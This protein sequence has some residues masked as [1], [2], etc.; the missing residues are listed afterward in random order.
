MA[1]SSSPP[2]VSACQD[3]EI[4]TTSPSALTPARE[5]WLRIETLHAVTYFDPSVTAAS[6][7]LGLRG[8]WRGYF[9][10]RAAPLGPVAGGVV[11]ATFFNFEPSFVARRVPEIWALASPAD[12]LAARSR[13]AADVLRRLA[14]GIEA[15]ADAVLPALTGAAARGIVA[16]RPLFAANRDVAAAGDPVAALWQA[17]TDLREHRGD[18]HVA[19]L[20]A[21]GIDGCEAHVLIALESGRPPEDLQRTRGWSPE[22]WADAT[23]RLAAR[24]LVATDGTLSPA[25]RTLRTDVEAT[26][27]RL[28]AEPFATAADTAADGELATLVA[29]LDPAARAVSAAGVIRYPNPIGLPPLAE[30]G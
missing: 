14:P 29:T 30:G 26:T 7:A 24:G 27:D 4:A 8:F 2:G 28:A 1:P 16:G 5:L 10:F 18:G 25:G 9:G 3:G 19:A 23:D 20:T 21:A 12:L 17:C 13:S 11:A 6:E 15:V 22:Q